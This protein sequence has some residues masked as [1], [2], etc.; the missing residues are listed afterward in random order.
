MFIKKDLRKVDEILSDESRETKSYSEI[1][2]SD[3]FFQA[4]TE[5]Y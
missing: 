5:K 1:F 2:L 3:C 4:T